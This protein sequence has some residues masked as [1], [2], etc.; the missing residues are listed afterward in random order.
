MTAINKIKT[1]ATATVKSKKIGVARMI[2]RKKVFVPKLLK[3]NQFYRYP[4]QSDAM[5]ISFKE[6]QYHIFPIS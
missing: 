1:V 4:M 2:I 5:A 6:L 3:A